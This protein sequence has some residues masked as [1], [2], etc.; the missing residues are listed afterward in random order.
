MSKKS[1]LLFPRLS[2]GECALWTGS[3]SPIAAALLVFDRGNYLTLTASLIGI[4][5]FIHDA[6]GNP[7]RQLFMVLFSRLYQLAAHPQP[8]ELESHITARRHI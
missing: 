2:G 7:F 6:K 8:S 4:T 3:A 5:A 1:D